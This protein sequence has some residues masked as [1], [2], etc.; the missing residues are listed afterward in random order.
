MAICKSCGRKIEKRAAVC[1]HCG[2]PLAV[3][4]RPKRVIAVVVLVLI[5][6]LMVIFQVSIL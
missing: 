5:N 3:P 2:A 6:A 4:K 1:N